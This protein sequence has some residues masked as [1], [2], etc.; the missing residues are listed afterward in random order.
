MNVPGHKTKIVC[1]I[2]PA[3]ESLPTMEAMIRAGM[4]IAR[5]NFSHGTFDSHRRIIQDLRRAS[6]SVGRPVT[7]MA[8]LPGPKMRIGSIAAEPVELQAGERFTLTTEEIVGDATRASV[9]F[10]NLP[11]VVSPGDKLFL[12]DGI[13]QLEVERVE[14]PEVRTR[15]QAGGELRSRKGLN[16]PGID[17]GISAFTEHD[18]SC[19]EFALGE[20]VEAVSQSFVEGD[21]DIRR[22]REAARALG[23]SPFVIAKIER[24]RAL[25]NIDAILAAADGIMIARGDLG[26]EIP[27]EEIAITQKRLMLMAN[28]LGK[29]VIT[30]TQMLESMTERRIPTR[31]EATDVANAI[32]DGTDCVMLSGESAM[33]KYPVEAVTM[34]ARIAAATEPHAPRRIVHESLRAY[35][36]EREA[37]PADLIALSLETMLQYS[38]P[39]LIV[40]PTKSGATARNIARFRHHVWIAAVS[41]APATCA[42]L[43]FSYGVQPLHEPSLPDEWV[44]YVRSQLVERGVT[45]GMAILIEGPSQKRP[46][47]NHRIEL[48]RLTPSRPIEG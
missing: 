7:I 25:T 28:R 38:S 1:T 14:G 22:V 46:E 36:H 47:A 6:D 37:S 17:L 3:S 23:Y 43:R 32:V 13:I 40:V 35:G 19:L 9:S 31:A 8:D 41:S 15:V 16:V 42:A 26:V 29:P 10:E 30:A 4:S 2:G 20:G 21:G 11:K 45:E 39:I 24:S 34:L 27:I 44:P 33:G 18:R 5:L 48:L 12:N